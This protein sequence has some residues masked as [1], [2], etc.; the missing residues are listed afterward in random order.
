MR[1]K[2]KWHLI[3]LVGLVLLLAI[4]VVTCGKP[5]PTPPTPP[6]PPVIS[7]LRVHF[8][9]VG[10]GDAILVDYGL[11][12]ILID[13]GGASPGVVT[14]LSHQKLKMDG[15]DL[16]LRMSVQLIT[17]LISS[18]YSLKITEVWQKKPIK[19]LD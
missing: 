15:L 11:V 19:F 6:K 4:S 14:Y 12:E 16:E 13:G 9:N 17:L 2:H 18:N 3:L 5:P 1:I 10:Q 7:E 8:I